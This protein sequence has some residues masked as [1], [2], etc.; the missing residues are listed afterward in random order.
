[1]SVT[2]HYE[3]ILIYP[4]QFIAEKVNEVVKNLQEIAA[5]FGGKVISHQDMGKRSIGFR[6]KKNT[7]GNYVYIDLDLEPAKVVEFKKA[8][9]LTEDILRYSIFLKPP[10]RPAS[11]YKKSATPPSHSATSSAKR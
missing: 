10:P 9:T 7:E 8:L 11:T 6:I 2:R 5:R 4:P 1:M 3:L